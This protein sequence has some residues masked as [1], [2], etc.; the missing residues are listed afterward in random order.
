MEV[1][2]K[3]P[4][5]YP[6]SLQDIMHDVLDDPAAMARRCVGEFR[7]ELIG[8][9]RGPSRRN[10]TAEAVRRSNPSWPQWTSR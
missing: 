7:A 5:K 2:D 8:A 3:V 6:D 9:S 4:A 10:R 1:F